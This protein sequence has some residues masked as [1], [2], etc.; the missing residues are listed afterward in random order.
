VDELGRGEV[1]EVEAREQ[2]ELLEHD[3]PLAPRAGLAH[4]RP[5]VVEGDRRLDGRLPRREIVPAKQSTLPRAERVDRLGH[6]PAQKDVAGAVDLV[7]SPASG[8]L[9]DDPPVRRR[10]RAVPEQ[11]PRRGSGQVELRRP[12]P[13]AEQRLRG[14]D[15][16]GD[17]GHDRIPLLRVPDR[18]LRHLGEPH[19]PEVA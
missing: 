19:R 8:G 11:R 17:P 4:R 10:E 12:G 9:L 6:E 7:L 14:A 5:A 15:R 2:R 16:R 3:G 18:V 1:G 13:A